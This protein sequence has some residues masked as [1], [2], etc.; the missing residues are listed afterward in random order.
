MKRENL[1]M[2]KS[3]EDIRI[4]IKMSLRY[5]GHFCFCFCMKDMT[6]FYFWGGRENLWGGKGGG[7][8]NFS[9]YSVKKN[10]LQSQ[11][12]E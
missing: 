8:K 9:E 2:G 4:S 5:V 10:G 3:C 7:E 1:K 12:Q 6:L 11:I